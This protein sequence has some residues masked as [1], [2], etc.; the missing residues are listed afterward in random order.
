M[1][2]VGGEEAEL[3]YGENENWQIP[4]QDSIKE[5]WELYLSNMWNSMIISSHAQCDSEDN[6]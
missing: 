4:N 6:V 1:G 2:Y 3:L 5:F